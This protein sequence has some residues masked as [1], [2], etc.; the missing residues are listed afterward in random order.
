MLA[1]GFDLTPESGAAC[2]LIK[3]AMEEAS[4]QASAC[5]RQRIDR[6]R[7]MRRRKQE[8]NSKG[9]ALIDHARRRRSMRRSIEIASQ[10]N[11]IPL[12][13]STSFLRPIYISAG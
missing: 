13:S 1:L 11:A 3:A 12:E 6:S 10:I 8:E 9:I 5:S 2:G 7:K 4:R